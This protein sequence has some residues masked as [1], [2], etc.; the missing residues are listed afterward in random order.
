MST[1]I[2]G[3]ER[4]STWTV[5]LAWG[6]VAL[7]AVATAWLMMRE[8]PLFI[9]R[10]G[11]LGLF[12]YASRILLSVLFTSLGALI[13]THQPGNRIGWLMLLPALATFSSVSSALF[14]EPLTAPPAEASALLLVA[15]WADRI[16]WAFALIPLFLVLLLFPTGR[17]PSRRWGSLVLALVA[18][19]ALL[20]LFVGL[21]EHL[22]PF[23]KA[24]QIDNPIGVIPDVWVERL[25]AGPLQQLLGV[26][27]LLCAASLF[28][29]YRRGS[30]VER[31]QIKWIAYTST[32]LGL[33]LLFTVLT[34]T[35]TGRGWDDGDL[36]GTAVQVPSGLMLL[37]TPVAITIAILRHHLFDI[38]L[39]IR[40]TLVYAVLTGVLGAIYLCTI[41]TLQALF[42]RLTGQQSELA[43]VAS[44]LAIAALFGPLRER[45]QRAIDRRFD[46]SRYD[47]RLV[48]EQFAA[49]AQRE[50]ELDTLSADLLATVDET[51]KPERVTLW[52]ARR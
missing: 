4:R 2:P 45:L 7:A 10:S 35:T 28:V 14:V 31:T 39:I 1:H 50:A 32:L 52:L 38:H 11:L 43:V 24:W 17:P 19:E 49:R 3:S 21:G 12:V 27:A 41:V 36:I 8:A 16:D 37:A 25:Y 6:V 22:V 47:A 33:S 15:V 23:T 46:R 40:R 42:V 34:M 30:A 5:W 13:I 48:L 20:I 18:L 26:L 44:T 51:L 9:D 29:R